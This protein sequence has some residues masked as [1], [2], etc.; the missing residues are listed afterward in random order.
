M[1]ET[2]WEGN[3][4]GK[5]GGC[6]RGGDSTPLCGPGSGV[7]GAPLELN[8][9]QEGCN[10]ATACPGSLLMVFEAIVKVKFELLPF[11]PGIQYLYSWYRQE[12]HNVYK[13]LFFLLILFEGITTNN[14]YWGDLT[15]YLTIQVI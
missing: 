3:R 13:H 6:C 8:L 12:T 4:D 2:H 9:L 15:P 11:I 7:P 5:A 10:G 1:G 14:K